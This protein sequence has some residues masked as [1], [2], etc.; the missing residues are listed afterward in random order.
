MLA[1]APLLHVVVALSPQPQ[2]K[3]AAAHAGY[4]WVGP[5]DSWGL[6]TTEP[7]Q[8]CQRCMAIATCRYWTWLGGDHMS[9]FLRAN[10]TCKNST[11]APR[12]DAVCGQVGEHPGSGAWPPPPSPT[13]LPPPQPPPPPPPPPGPCQGDLDCELL[14]KCVSGV[15]HCSPGFVGPTCG[16]LDL[17]PVPASTHGKI[18]PR[19]EAPYAK[20][21]KTKHHGS[22]GWSFAPAFDPKT[23]RYVAAVEAVCDKWGADVWLAAI[24][25]AH[26]DS[27]W[28]FE[29]RL[30]PAG[31]NCPHM[32]RLK[33]GTFA[34]VMNAMAD[35][36]YPA[37][38]TKDPT[39]PVCVGD[40]VPS[41]DL[42]EPVLR[43]CGPG[44]DP[45]RGHRCLC[46]RGSPGCNEKS[47][48][49]VATTESFPGGPWRIAPLSITGVGWAPY[50]ATVA[51]IGTS[52]PTAVQ[53]E[54]G[55]TLL[56]F[57]S[58]RG[59]WP[60]I[61]SKVT[62]RAEGEHTGFALSDSIEGPFTVSGNLSWQ[63]GNDECV[64][65]VLQLTRTGKAFIC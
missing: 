42:M 45:A 20:H 58:H 52:N 12:D 5:S 61:E 37:N 31:T 35:G 57:R 63:Y 10:T 54:D 23:K 9:C 51:S 3:S 14:G 36:L 41:P 65:P 21:D 50:N 24:S 49:Y 64:P 46:S 62:H 11:G 29:R 4:Q 48:V 15:C 7:A 28:R 22:I 60:E 18:W 32:K 53:L 38:E 19:T 26:P 25:S 1:L 30:G 2:C 16:Q 17:L 47:A 8:C 13:P 44:E 56:S 27:G 43:P 55:R 6:N 40:S 33:N 59:Y 39:A 34:L